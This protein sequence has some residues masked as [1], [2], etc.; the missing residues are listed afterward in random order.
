MF[1]GRRGRPA[2]DFPFQNNLKP[3]AMPADQRLG[4]DDHQR[5]FPIA[6]TRPGDERETGRVVQSFR[7]HDVESP[8]RDKVKEMEAE[9][10]GLLASLVAQ[11]THY[12]HLRRDLD[13]DQFIWE[14]IGIYL[15]H[16]VASRFLKSPVADHRA[17]TAFEALLARA[18]TP[19]RIQTRR[20]KSARAAQT[21]MTSRRTLDLRIVSESQH[22]AHCDPSRKS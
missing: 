6:E 4:F 11:A 2:C 9:W 15:S 1:S 10:R 5:L 21:V 17:Q 22:A 14:L 20:A 13:A 3:L 12:G 16:H 18:E 8:V 19:R 7:L